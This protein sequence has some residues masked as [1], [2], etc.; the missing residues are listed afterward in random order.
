MKFSC[1]NSF[2]ED[3]TRLLTL[4]DI[5]TRVPII[6]RVNKNVSHTAEIT[7][8]RKKECGLE[9]RICDTLDASITVLCF[10]KIIGY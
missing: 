1:K 9:H 8:T 4:S 10:Q 7:F 6:G 2:I 3:I 5:K